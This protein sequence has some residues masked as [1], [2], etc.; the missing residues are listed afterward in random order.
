[1]LNSQALYKRIIIWREEKGW[2]ENKLCEMSDFSH[3]IV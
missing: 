2:S 1:M 3:S